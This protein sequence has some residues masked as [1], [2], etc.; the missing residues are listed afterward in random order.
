MPC[1][2]KARAVSAAASSRAASI[3]SWRRQPEQSLIILFFRW[4]GHDG[5]LQ[6]AND[7][8]GGRATIRY[9]KSRGAEVAEC[10][11][12]ALFAENTARESVALRGRRQRDQGRYRGASQVGRE[13]AAKP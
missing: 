13:G 10:G 5:Q 4:R 12:P 7:A 6:G 8:Q 1:S 9:L 3:P 2:I 11:P